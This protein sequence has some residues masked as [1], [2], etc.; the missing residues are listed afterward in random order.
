MITG[1]DAEVFHQE[2]NQD[3]LEE[4]DD[5]DDRDRHQALLDA[6]KLAMSDT[7]PDDEVIANAHAAA[8]IAAIWSGAPYTDSETAAEYSYIRAGIGY[9]D[10]PLQDAAKAILDAVSESDDVGEGV[11][12]FLEA[13]S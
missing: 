6:C 10:E 9:C 1:W 8:I 12:E 7:D 13:L 2:V 4:L 3:F 11:D 5:L